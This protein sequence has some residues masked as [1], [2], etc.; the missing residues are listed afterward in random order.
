MKQKLYRPKSLDELKKMGRNDQAALWAQYVISKYRRQIRALWY[1]ISCENM[2]LKIAPKHMI[3][4]RK[5]A[6]AP[7][8]C[9]NKVYKTKYKLSPGTELIKT[10]R[11]LEFRVIVAGDNDFIFRDKH[12]KTLSAVAREICGIKVSG[13]DFFGL[14]NKRMQIRN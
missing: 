3:K 5:Y 8:E 13:P 12:Y 1:Y 4:I 6:D 14:N 2:N 7:E 9:L 11:N 10:F